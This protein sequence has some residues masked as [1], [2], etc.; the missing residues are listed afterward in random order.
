MYTIHSVTYVRR[1]L[2]CACA[3]DRVWLSRGDPDIKIQLLINSIFFSFLIWTFSVAERVAAGSHK[4][5]NRQL[6]V[7]V[8]PV[9]VPTPPSTVMI[10]GGD[11]SKAEMYKLYFENPRKGGGDITDFTEDEEQQSILITFNDPEGNSLT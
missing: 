10:R 9:E 11:L 2:K 4:V 6:E 1:V 3:F 5:G 7:K 8:A